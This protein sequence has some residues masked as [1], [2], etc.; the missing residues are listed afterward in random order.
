MATLRRHCNRLFA[1][2]GPSN[3]YCFSGYCFPIWF[4]ISISIWVAARRRWCSLLVG[5]CR[6]GVRRLA[7]GCLSAPRGVGVAPA[8]CS[9][10]CPA[11]CP[12]GGCDLAPRG[13]GVGF[14]FCPCKRV[15]IRASRRRRWFC[16]LPLQAG[17]YSRLAAQALPLC[18][19]APPF[20][21]AAKKGGKESRST[22]YPVLSARSQRWPA[23]KCCPRRD[24]VVVRDEIVPRV[25]HRS[26][27]GP[28]HPAAHRCARGRVCIGSHWALT[29]LG[30]IPWCPPATPMRI[31]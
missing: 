13:A 17:A 27:K 16:F 19:A 7:G 12:A 22:R 30:E 25:A 2:G 10:F 24:A 5:F 4:S 20:F 14:A 23:P 21:A 18:G 3:K 26:G 8:F 29:D 6:F 9:A 28:A 11:F 31:K 15:L 1:W